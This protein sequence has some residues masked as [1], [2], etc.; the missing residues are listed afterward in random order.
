MPQHRP[1]HTC[2]RGADHRR[3][4]PHHPDCQIAVALT[5]GDA[6]AL[7]SAEQEAYDT[8]SAAYIAW[9][10]EP[11]SAARQAALLATYWAWQSARL[12]CLRAKARRPDLFLQIRS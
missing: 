7:A 12:A 4:A 5:L 9:Q 11:E 8:H 10:A 3:S 6:R 2:P 1:H